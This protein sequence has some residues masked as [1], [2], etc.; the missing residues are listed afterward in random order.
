[1]I[2]PAFELNETE[3]DFIKNNCVHYTKA[4][5]ELGANLI[6]GGPAMVQRFVCPHVSAGHEK[7]EYTTGTAWPAI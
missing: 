7:H 5:R 1:M 2:I 3:F 4:K 6:K